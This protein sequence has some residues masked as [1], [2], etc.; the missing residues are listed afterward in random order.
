MRFNSIF[1]NAL[2]SPTCVWFGGHTC[3]SEVLAAFQ[4]L[5]IYDSLV[6]TC[7]PAKSSS[8]HRGVI[9]KIKELHVDTHINPRETERR[10]RIFHRLSEFQFVLVKIERTSEQDI[11]AG[12]CG[13]GS[14]HGW[15]S[16]HRF[17]FMSGSVKIHLLPVRWKPQNRTEQNRTDRL[18]FEPHHTALDGLLT[19]DCKNSC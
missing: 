17:S 15:L 13:A 3:E 12:Q 1:V 10:T 5:G 9:N 18:P 11:R 7:S 16:A 19:S 6:N 4:A 8:W 14:V 2:H